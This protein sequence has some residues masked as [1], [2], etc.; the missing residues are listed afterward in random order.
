MS[1]HGSEAFAG[2]RWAS[3]WQSWFSHFPGIAVRT[4]A[5]AAGLQSEWKREIIPSKVISLLV[6][7]L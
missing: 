1:Y 6:L 4:V 2:L 5:Y 7:G 3:S